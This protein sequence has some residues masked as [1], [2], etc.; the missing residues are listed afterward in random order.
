MKNKKYH[1]V[2][3]TP[4]SSTNIHGRSLSLVSTGASIHSVRLKRLLF[5]PPAYPS[6]IMRSCKYCQLGS[7]MPTSHIPGEQR[8]YKKKKN[9]TKQK[10]YNLEHYI[11]YI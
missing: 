2:G 6:G 1:T 3:T 11:Q 8:Y 4:K 7:K 9:K 10:P 5:A